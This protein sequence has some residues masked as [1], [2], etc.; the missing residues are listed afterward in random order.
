[1]FF[2]PKDIKTITQPPQLAKAIK[3][4]A[5]RQATAEEL[6]DAANVIVTEI[7]AERGSRD[8]DGKPIS[9]PQ[10]RQN[11]CRSTQEADMI[12]TDRE[13]HPNSPLARFARDEEGSIT[14]CDDTVYICRDLD[15]LP[16]RARV[17]IATKGERTSPVIHAGIET[18]RHKLR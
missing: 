15:S 1:M 8:W 4:I 14:V 9:D 18:L 13:I 7:T 5:R 3:T 17:W 16:R 12:P 6:R 10:R 2:R 11:H